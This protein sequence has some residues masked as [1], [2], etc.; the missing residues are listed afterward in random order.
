[1]NKRTQSKRRDQK[2]KSHPL[3]L[4]NKENN[5]N[6]KKANEKNKKKRR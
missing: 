2:D 4:I 3:T 1:M 5:N 6:N